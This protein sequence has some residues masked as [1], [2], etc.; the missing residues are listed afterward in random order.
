M[1][2]ADPARVRRGLAALV[3]LAGSCSTL[4]SAMGQPSGESPARVVLFANEASES[5]LGRVAAELR[6][7]G[8][9]VVSVSA[10]SSDDASVKSLPQLEAVARSSDALAAVQVVAVDGAVDLWIVN[11]DT[12]E[13]V[14]RRV[15]SADPAVAA[16]RSVET[17][18][19]SL[20]DLLAL[21]PRTPEA[22]VSRERPQLAIPPVMDRRDTDHFDVELGLGPALGTEAFDASWH[23]MGAFT[24]MWAARWGAHALGLAPL[25]SSQV[26]GTEGHASITFGLLGGGLTWQPLAESSWTPYISGGLAGALLYSR[27]APTAGF[28]GYSHYTPVACPY[29][30]AGARFFRAGPWRIHLSLLAGMSAPKPV[31]LFVDRRAGTWGRPLL[32]SALGVDFSW[33]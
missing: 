21:A 12:H 8:F 5:L 22:H 15:V 13:M 11:V 17:L 30:R 10:G 9:E 19:A 28:T 26:T 14:V 29:V 2:R 6:S 23:V 16:L 20:I 25:T 3:M 1:P 32:M 33:P 4:P 24:W 18:R 27:G 31:L 7:L